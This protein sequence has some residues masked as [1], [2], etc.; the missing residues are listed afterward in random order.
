MGGV[1]FLRQLQDVQTFHSS[2][3]E[4]NKDGGRVDKEREREAKTD[5]VITKEEVKFLERRKL[6]ASVTTPSL[7]PLSSPFSSSQPIFRRLQHN[8]SASGDSSNTLL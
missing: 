4:E 1:G 5:T 2:H 3:R 6:L 8:A 7:L